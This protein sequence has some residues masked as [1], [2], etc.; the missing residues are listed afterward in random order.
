MTEAYDLVVVQA[1]RDGNIAKLQELLDHDNDIRHGG[2]DSNKIRKS[3]NH[4][5]AC[6]RFGES[7]LHMA[8][9]R[10]DVQVVEFLVKVAKVDITVRDDFG[11]TILHDA[12]WT[13]I[14]NI[15]VVQILLEVVSPTFLLAPDVRGH[16]PF[17]YARR[18]HWSVWCNF[19]QQRQ[20][21]ILQRLEVTQ[22]VG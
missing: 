13:T 11:R 3:Y 9:R 17:H 12:C 8:C 16:T 18:E 19:L 15:Q 20:T 5:N 10:S 14:P 2:D 4:L 21:A 7:L 22:V 1:I 6:N